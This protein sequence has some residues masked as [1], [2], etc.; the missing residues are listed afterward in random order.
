MRIT[1]YYHT[2]GFNFEL[3][4]IVGSGKECIQVQFGQPPPPR[5]TYIA[6]LPKSKPTTQY[7]SRLARIT[8]I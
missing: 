7:K 8:I 3:D 5:P 6:H 1:Q 4:A 2:P